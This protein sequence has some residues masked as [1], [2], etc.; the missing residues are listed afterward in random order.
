MSTEI[1]AHE[2]TLFFKSLVPF[3]KTDL[4]KTI[5]FVVSCSNEGI[6][7]DFLQL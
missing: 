5:F 1:K 3:G 2:F 4:F 7:K 6:S